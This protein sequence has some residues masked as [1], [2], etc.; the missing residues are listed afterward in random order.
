VL[1]TINLRVKTLAAVAL[2]VMCSSMGDILLS[3]G[4]KQIGAVNISSAGALGQ[5]FVRI[6]INGS[7]WTGIALL[8]FCTMIYMI[9]LSWADYSFV[10]P[11]AA[12]SYAIVPVLGYLVLGEPVKTIRWAGVL[13]IVL[14]VFLISRT[15]PRTTEPRL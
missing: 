8:I 10:Q 2:M 3:R 7:V 14:G 13:F 15:A 1:D 11:S 5:T 9:V 12:F 4:M 6:L